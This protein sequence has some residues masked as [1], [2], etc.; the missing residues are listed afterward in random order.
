MQLLAAGRCEDDLV[1]GGPGSTATELDVT[2]GDRSSTGDRYLFELVG[3]SEPE[4]LA[5]RRE[6]G[7]VG[8]GTDRSGSHGKRIELIE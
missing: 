3:S 7:M 4:P 5:I 1:L 8:L 6:E 2:Q